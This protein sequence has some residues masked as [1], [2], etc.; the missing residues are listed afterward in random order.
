MSIVHPK[1]GKS[2]MNQKDTYIVG[3]VEKLVEFN[4][5]NQGDE[6][7]LAD[8]LMSLQDEYEEWLKK[9]PLYDFNTSSLEF[10][11]AVK[12]Y[13]DTMMHNKFIE[14]TMNAAIN[15]MKGEKPD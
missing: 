12:L 3:L 8:K 5:A 13:F 10:N 7:A 14:I 15:S 11:Y 1:T 9:H 6:K 2:V 4:K